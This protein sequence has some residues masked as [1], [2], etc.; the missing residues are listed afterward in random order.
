[1]KISDACS[2]LART[3]YPRALIEEYQTIF[4]SDEAKPAF[5]KTTAD[6]VGKISTFVSQ[7]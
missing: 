7:F 6:E 3:D 4:Y 5:V 2:R 1:M